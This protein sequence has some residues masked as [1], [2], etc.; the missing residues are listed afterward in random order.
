M[1]EGFFLF[2]PVQGS[3]GSNLFRGIQAQRPRFEV[4]GG[5]SLKLFELI[6]ADYVA[7]KRYA[8][9]SYTQVASHVKTVPI[10]NNFFKRKFLRK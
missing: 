6:E 7:I 3:N 5:I 4:H 10:I 8:F 2:K 1:N 9:L